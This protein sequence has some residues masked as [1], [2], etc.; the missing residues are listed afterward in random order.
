MYISVFIYIYIFKI[1]IRVTYVHPTSNK[2]H[3]H[4][5]RPRLDPKARGKDFQVASPMG[6]WVDDKAATWSRCPKTFALL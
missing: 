1:N 6:R 2:G 5:R 4:I 3:I